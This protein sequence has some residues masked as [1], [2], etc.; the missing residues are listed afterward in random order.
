VL[1]TG[2]RVP[3]HRESGAVRETEHEY[4]RR[5]TPG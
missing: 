2:V 1:H 5:A 3:H 4:S